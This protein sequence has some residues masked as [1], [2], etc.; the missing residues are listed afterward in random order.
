MMFGV[1]FFSL[2]YYIVYADKY[3]TIKPYGDSGVFPHYGNFSVFDTNV[4]YFIGGPTAVNRNL[5][6][7]YLP[8]TGGNAFKRLLLVAY[9]YKRKT[10][11]Q[12]RWVYND[13]NFGFLFYDSLRNRLLGLR[14]N[15]T[16]TYYIEE[17][18]IET[19]DTVKLYT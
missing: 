11:H 16:F 4:Y 12:S 19:L 1:L 15:A 18:D 6:Y 13:G 8:I 7:I 5:N 14:T 9:N 2:L 3:Y 17:Y 10:Y